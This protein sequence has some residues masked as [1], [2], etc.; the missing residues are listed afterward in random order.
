MVTGALTGTVLLSSEKIAVAF[1]VIN[2]T[3][4]SVMDLKVLR[5]SITVSI[6][7]LSLILNNNTNI[8]SLCLVRR[9]LDH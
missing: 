6:Y 7:A 1:S 3:C 2:L 5:L 4:F 9:N 8:D